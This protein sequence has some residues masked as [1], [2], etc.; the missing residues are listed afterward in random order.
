MY[1]FAYGSNM[2][3]QQM[4]KRCPSARLIGPGVLKDY[5]LDFT[6]SAPERWGG[7]GCADVVLNKGSEV[8]GLLYELS[9][10]DIENLDRAEGPRYRRFSVS[11]QIEHQPAVPAFV[12]EVIDKAPFKS[13]DSQYLDIIKRA[14]SEYAFPKSYQEYLDSVSVQ[15]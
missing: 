12:Y 4:S 7:G 9:R 15:V 1:Y 14:A 8:W 11:I 10:E 6:I 13:P 2:G 5:K 3:Q